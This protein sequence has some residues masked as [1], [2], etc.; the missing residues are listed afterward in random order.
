M[1]WNY[2]KWNLLMT[3]RFYKTDIQFK[4]L[5]KNNIFN[6]SFNDQPS[7]NVLP[8][9][10]ELNIQPQTDKG[11]EHWWGVKKTEHWKRLKYWI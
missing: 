9:R 5:L 6:P 4:N 11:A 8:Y 7:L 10:S 1:N 3:R 2:S